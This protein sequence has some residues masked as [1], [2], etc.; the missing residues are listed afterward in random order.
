MDADLAMPK[1]S[2]RHRWITVFVVLW[3][4][5]FHYE[6]LR[7]SYLQPLLHRPLP[8]V[9]WLFPP[10]G[11]IM[12]YRVEP[13]EGRAE[14][15]GITHGVPHL[16][17]PHDIF[18]TRFVWYDNIRRNVLVSVLNQGSAPGFCRFLRRRFPTYDGFVVVYLQYASVTQQPPAAQRYEA[19]RC[20]D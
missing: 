10:A 7:Y 18:R 9:Q 8:K 6:S 2:R 11:W 5:V 3:L 19:Y 17:D 12:F 4:L 14:V 20:G 16:I 15:Y 13:S 1:T